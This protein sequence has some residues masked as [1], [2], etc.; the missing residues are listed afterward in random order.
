MFFCNFFFWLFKKKCVLM[1]LN[2]FWCIYY[3]ILYCKIKSCNSAT[4]C[5]VI[6]NKYTQYK[7]VPFSHVFL[8]EHVYTVIF[9]WAPRDIRHNGDIHF[10]SICKKYENNSKINFQVANKQWLCGHLGDRTTQATTTIWDV[11][12]LDLRNVI[13]CNLNLIK[14]V[15]S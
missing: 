7:K 12:F 10:P 2:V 13:W 11:F 8:V 5:D 15:F 4:G 1:V 6:I 9:E 3:V 14:F